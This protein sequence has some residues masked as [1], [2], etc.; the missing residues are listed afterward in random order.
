MF[1]HI[2]YENLD[3]SNYK[4]NL[5]ELLKFWDCVCHEKYDN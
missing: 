2:K 4:K 3:G 5:A 1:G